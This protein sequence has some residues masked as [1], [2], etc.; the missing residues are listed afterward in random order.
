MSRVRAPWLVAIV[1]ASFLLR[2]GVG[3]AALD[4]RPVPG[5]VHLLGDRPLARRLRPPADPGRI[6]PLPGTPR[7]DPHRAGLARR[8]RRHRV[9]DRPGDRRAR[10]VARGDSRVPARPPARAVEAHQPRARRARRARARSRLCLLRL[11]GG[12]RLP[13]RPRGGRRRGVRARPAERAGPSSRSSASRGWRP[14]P[15]SSSPSC[16]SSSSSGS[17]RSAYENGESEPRFASRRCRSRSSPFRSWPC[18]SAGQRARSATTTTSSGSAP[19][20]WR[21]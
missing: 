2:T 20:R 6:R 18:S 11:V 14:S 1:G 10:D 5:R 16:R 12:V 15:A 19:S 17:S 4:A 3:L 13:A 9:P 8:R 21:C 7:A